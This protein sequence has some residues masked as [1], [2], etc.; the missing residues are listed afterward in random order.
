ML[1]FKESYGKKE[2]EEGYVPTEKE[3]YMNEKQQAYFRDLL[4]EWR[5]Q[6]E[7]E[8][9]VDQTLYYLEKMRKKYFMKK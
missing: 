9:Q 5:S 1:L 8:S 3:E 2:Y 4:L 6:L 7:K